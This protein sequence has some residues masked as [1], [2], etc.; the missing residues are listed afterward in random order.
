[1]SPY[2]VR[3]LT[4]TP[5][6]VYA[7]VQ[8]GGHANRFQ[9]A[10]GDPGGDNFSVVHG[11]G[12]DTSVADMVAGGGTIYVTFAATGSPGPTLARIQGS[13]FVTRALPDPSC[14]TLAPSSATDLLVACGWYQAGGGQGARTLYGSTNGGDTWTK[15]PDPAFGDGWITDGVADAGGGHAVIA[16]SSAGGAGLLATTD[17]AQHWVE[18]LR[19]TDT[20]GASWGDLGFEN[21]TTGVVVFSPNSGGTLY[22]TTDGGVTWSKVRFSA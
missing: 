3:S 8:D 10:R 5:A 9:L 12:P 20:G 11:F 16:T 7:V 15:L 21:R 4:A 6:G 14:G 18:V 1:V 17:G 22:R 19:M 13:T 2:S